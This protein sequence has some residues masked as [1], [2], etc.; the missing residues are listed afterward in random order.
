[1]G[2]N[3]GNACAGVTCLTESGNTK[4]D[5]RRG[6]P[7][8]QGSAFETSWVK[9]CPQEVEMLA[10]PEH[11]RM[12]QEQARQMKDKLLGGVSAMW[13]DRY[14]YI[15][16][17]GAAQE[18]FAKQNGLMP[19]A[20]QMFPRDLDASFALSFAGMV[21]PRAGVTAST[22]WNYQSWLS[23]DA[24]LDHAAWLA[25]FLRKFGVQSCPRHCDCDELTAC[26]EVYPILKTGAID[27]AT[28]LT[29]CFPSKL[30]GTQAELGAPLDS[31]KLTFTS[32]LRMCFWKGKECGGV[33]CS[34]SP[35]T[36]T[37]ECELRLPGTGHT[38][39]EV[40]V[41]HAECQGV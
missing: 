5:T 1:M 21:W 15:F 9:L 27:D 24:L 35:L 36:R 14:C 11:A 40:Y 12:Q 17:C 18:W 33:S 4:C 26:D 38:G 8:L 16:Q 34:V 37:R 30:E 20:F 3:S 29:S 6:M 19:G 22:L 39:S 41:K 31:L 7:F 2:I 25:A 32:S 28:F 10:S 23:E 13:T